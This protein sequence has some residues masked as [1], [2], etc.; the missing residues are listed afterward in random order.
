MTA[1]GEPIAFASLDFYYPSWD[2][3][4]LCVNDGEHLAMTTYGTISTNLAQ[5]VAMRMDGGLLRLRVLSKYEGNRRIG[6]S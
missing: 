1:G 4:K 5:S 2:A 3:E 6:T